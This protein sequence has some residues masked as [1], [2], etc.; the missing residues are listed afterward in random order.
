MAFDVRL[1]LAVCEVAGMESIHWHSMQDHGF[2]TLVALWVDSE[3][4]LR[5]ARWDNMKNRQ[6]IM[7]IS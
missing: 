1:K 7:I 3:G 6:V 4:R 2:D 5:S